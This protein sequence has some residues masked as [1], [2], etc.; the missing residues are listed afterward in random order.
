MTDPSW[1]TNSK[2]SQCCLVYPQ[3]LGTV[4]TSYPHAETREGHC[5]KVHLR[6][7]RLK[8]KLRRKY[9]LNL[10]NEPPHLARL[11]SRGVEI[12]AT[13]NNSSERQGGGLEPGITRLQVQHPNNS[14]TPPP[15]WNSLLSLKTLP[16]RSVQLIFSCS[17][18]TKKY[19]Y[20]FLGQL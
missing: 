9:V 8:S 3:V 4:I 14:D 6:K 5:K 10:L 13:E 15:R 11:S 12:G 19:L 7:K 20:S 16:A 17:D 2:K 1:K 18:L